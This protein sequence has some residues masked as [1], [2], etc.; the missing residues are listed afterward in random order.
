[1]IEFCFLL[2][3][4]PRQNF[5]ERSEGY[6]LKVL[7]VYNVVD[8]LDK[9]QSD[10]MLAEQETKIVEEAV[11]RSLRSFGHQ[12]TS[13]PIRHEL[14]EPLREFDPNEW[15]IFN[16]CESIRDKTYLEPYVISVYEYLHFRY[17]G[18][19]RLTLATCLNKARAKEI[20][21]A[22][23][24]PTAPFQ[25]IG[26]PTVRRKLDFPLFVKPVA[27]DASL[28]ITL[29]SVVENERELRQ[30]L[31]FIWNT[32]RQPALVEQF[33]QGREFNV[34]VLGNDNPR[35]LPL[36]E[37]N[38]SQIPDP[39]ARIV[40]FKGKWVE[41]S[42][43]YKFTQVIS[44]AKVSESLRNKIGEVAVAAYR[45]M[46]VRDYGRVD[47]R[48][49]N[50]VP[51]VLEV[52]PN[53]DLSPDAGIARAARV[54]GMSYA[55]LADEIVRLAAHRYRLKEPRPRIISLR[56]KARANG[57]DAVR[58]IPVSAFKTETREEL[59][60]AAAMP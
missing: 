7:V 6:C 47:I 54:A 28:G 19:N 13:V 30:Q 41:E 38:F 56:L 26:P 29:D 18:S 22:H 34:T 23:G 60:S 49:M 53:A 39:K 16:L 27:E 58:S 11:A 3:R 12:V 43:D 9:G 57:T 36:S 21:K 25:V 15:L 40:T 59:Q 31:R 33:I 44:P 1:V 35:V 14:W 51:Y 5:E 17:T 8:L 4:P 46:G 50:G 20:L 2:A 37:I 42:D 45:A 52:N 32:Y 55:M 10:D 48:V 24:I